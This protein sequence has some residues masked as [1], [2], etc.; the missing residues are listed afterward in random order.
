M[1]WLLPKLGR[2]QP[3]GEEEAAAAHWGS[4]DGAS[5]VRAGPGFWGGCLKAPGGVSGSCRSSGAAR[6][7]LEPGPRLSAGGKEG[8]RLRMEPAGSG[9]S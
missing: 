9:P 2:D 4:W 3:K 1:P 8:K 7:R 6:G 5:R